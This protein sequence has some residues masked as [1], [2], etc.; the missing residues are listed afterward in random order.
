MDIKIEKNE[1]ATEDESCPQNRQNDAETQ[2]GNSPSSILHPPSSPSSLSASFRV[3]CGQTVFVFLLLTS[4]LFAASSGG[5]KPVGQDG[6][7]R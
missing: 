5:I 2:Q 6:A 1:G 3:F 4:S 7:Y